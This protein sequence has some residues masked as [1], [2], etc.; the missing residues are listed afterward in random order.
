MRETLPRLYSLVFKEQGILLWIYTQP[1]NSR[2]ATAYMQD[3]DIL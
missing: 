2:A 1:Y 3:E